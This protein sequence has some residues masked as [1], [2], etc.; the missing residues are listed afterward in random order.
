MATSFNYSFLILGIEFTD[1]M[2]FFSGILVYKEF[3]RSN[4]NETTT[5]IVVKIAKR[6]MRW[7]VPHDLSQSWTSVNDLQY[8]FRLHLS[9]IIVRFF[10]AYILPELGDGPLWYK[11]REDA[12]Y[13][14]INLLKA[15]LTFPSVRNDK[16][17]NVTTPNYFLLLYRNC[18]SLY[19]LH[20]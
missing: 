17:V 10:Y 5:D 2:F 13:C 4:E 15:L 19:F 9:Y 6:W 11:A 18:I 14:E 16:I 12:A 3:N 8:F 20:S 1:L 7:V